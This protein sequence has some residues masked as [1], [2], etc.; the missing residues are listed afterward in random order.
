M[1][2]DPF[3]QAFAGTDW[4]K[5]AAA[6]PVVRAR[7]VGHPASTTPASPGAA[8]PTPPSG[9][10]AGDAP[11]AKAAESS[12]PF[13]TFSDII[14]AVNP[15]QQLPIIDGIYR[16]F[17]GDTIRPQGSIL[18]GLLYGGLVG[19]AIATGMVLFHEVAGFDPED[20]V[21]SFLTGEDADATQV[22]AAQ[23][24]AKPATAQPPPAPSITVA[25]AN[26]AAL[27]QLALDLAGGG[28][29]TS[30]AS[31]PGPQ[32]PQSQAA[33]AQTAQ[34]QM[35]AAAAAPAEGPGPLIPGLPANGSSHLT[36]L[37]SHGVVANNP[38][39]PPPPTIVPPRRFTG[40]FQTAAM[41]APSPTGVPPASPPAAGAGP[42]SPAGAPLAA[43]AAMPARPAR[44]PGVV[45]PTG[46]N[47]AMRLTAPVI[48]PLS[49][50]PPIKP[51]A[52]PQSPPVQPLDPAQPITD[53]PPLPAEPLSPDAV[54]QV[55]MRNLDKYQAL[56]RAA[57]R[58]AAKPVGTAP[59]A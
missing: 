34:S 9:L 17:S 44:P 7:V 14:D 25:D 28:Q 20:A 29:V 36:R 42:G 30:G 47:P 32:T 27:H 58:Q 41:A 54:S 45:L 46:T 10:S 19:G 51:L 31:T 24:D 38:N 23:P 22:A 12:Q 16:H 35:F 15:L 5:L 49:S 56:A 4:D 3:T 53:P 40:T 55:M 50:G 57:A 11:T 37:S 1:S 21:I 39:P 48:N 59:A 52:A 8:S 13:L 33:Q 18:G 2:L 6:V 26:Q 43:R